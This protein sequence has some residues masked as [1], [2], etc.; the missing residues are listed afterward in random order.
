MVDRV[1]KRAR[2]RSTRRGSHCYC[3]ACEYAK[4]ILVNF[5]GFTDKEEAAPVAAVT[6]S[7]SAAPAAIF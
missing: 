3:H 2:G 4:K 7:A 6:A 1:P 5:C